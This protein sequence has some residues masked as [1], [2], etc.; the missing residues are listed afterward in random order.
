[1]KEFK[2]LL[3]TFDKVKKFVNTA[4][5]CVGDVDLASQSNRYVVDGKSVMGVFSLDL[6]KEL[7]C[8]CHEDKDSESLLNFDR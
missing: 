7:I 6:S 2:V 4:E 3:N 8:R 1:M 5:K